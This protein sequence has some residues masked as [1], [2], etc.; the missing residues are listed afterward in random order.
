V[1][2][3][4]WTDGKKVV[5]GHWQYNWASDSFTIFLDSTD[6][7]T[8]R[9]RVIRTTGDTPEWGRFKRQQP[10]QRAEGE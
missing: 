4:T 10:T 9:K 3:A 7:I 2:A 8:G 5:T 1:N 6:R